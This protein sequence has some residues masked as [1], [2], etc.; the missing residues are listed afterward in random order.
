MIIAIYYLFE[1]FSN[2]SIKRNA[3]LAGCFI[4]FSLLSKGPIS[5]YALLLPFLIT[6]GLVY[7]FK[8]SRKQW[9]SA[10]VCLAIALVIGG[11]WYLYVRLADPETFKAIAKKETANWGS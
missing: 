8:F 5:A 1:L 4:G 11:W 6:Y 7:K 10:M 2:E 3:L 9:M